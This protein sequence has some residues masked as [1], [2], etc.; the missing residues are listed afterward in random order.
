M[1]PKQ[2]RFVEEYLVDLNA[3]AAA[4]R[5]GYSVR[6]ADAIGRE[7]LGKPTVAAAIAAAQQNR[8]ERTQVDSDWVLK[9]LHRDATADIA[10]LFDEQGRM[11]PAD[12]WP[13]AWRQG[14]V[15]GVES[16]EEY[17]FDDGVKRPI[18]MVR[19]LKLSERSKYVEMIG[20]HV[21]VAAFRD[22]V[23]HTGKDGGPIPVSVDL[24]GATVEQLRAI[25]SL[26][27]PDAAG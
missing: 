11:K 22:R 3:A 14:L 25:A 19:K 17:A 10:D 13:D 18:G 16:F 26:K 5:A 24:S 6:T 15:V 9:R 8:S 1:T 4:R 7:N 27:L 20:R 2:Q 23:E 21:D 12:Q